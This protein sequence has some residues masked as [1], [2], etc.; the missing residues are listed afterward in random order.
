MRDRARYGGNSL[1]IKD[2]NCPP[3]SPF[4]IFVSGHIESAQIDD[5]D[6]ICCKYDFMAGTDWSIVDVSSHIF[7]IFNNYSHNTL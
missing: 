2:E 7:K 1:N 3:Y 6:G 5:H 4:Y